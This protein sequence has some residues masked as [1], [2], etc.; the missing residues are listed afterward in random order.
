[1]KDAVLSGQVF[2]AVLLLASLLSANVDA[3]DDPSRRALADTYRSHV[4]PILTRY[5]LGC[6]SEESSEGDLDLERFPSYDAARKDVKP[7]Q[8]MVEMLESGEMPPRKKPQPTADERRRLIAWVRDFLASE[9]IARAGDPGRVGLRRL[10]NAEYDGT[11]RELTTVDLRPAREFP[12]DGAAGEGFTNASEALNMS[13]ALLAKYLDAAKEIA[14]HAILLPDGFRFSRGN[15]RRDW[16]DESV[17]GLREFYARYAGG[18]GRLPIGPYLSALVR[19]REALASGAAGVEAVA[20]SEKLHPGYLSAVFRALSAEDH[21]IPMDRLRSIWMEAPAD[22]GALGS[23]VAAWQASLWKFQPIGSYRYGNIVRQAA[24]EPTWTESG[25]VRVGRKPAPGEDDVVL[26]LVAGDLSGADGTGSVEWHR[27][28]FERSGRPALL[29]RDYEEFGP[30]YEI[31]RA[32]L[33]ADAP[34]YLAAAIEAAADRRLA[35]DAL[36]ARDDLDPAWLRRW[37]AVAAPQSGA[38]DDVGRPTPAVRLELLGDRKPAGPK[39]NGWSAR[40]ADLPTLIANSSDRAEQVPGRISPHQVAVHPTPSECAAVAWT[41]PIGGRVRVDARVTHAH[42]TCGNG[43]GWWLESRRGD[44]A[45]ILAEG[46]LGLGKETTVGPRVLD[47]S[48]G[49]LVVLAVDA[50]EG[51]H[52]C[53]LTEIALSLSESGGPARRWDLAADVA[54]NVGEGNPHPDR[55]GN[56]AVWSFLKGPARS[57]SGESAP[58]VPAGSILGRW[59]EAAADPGRRAEAGGLAGRLRD[60]LAGPRPPE[61]TGPDRKLYDNLA[62]PD[63]PLMGEIPPTL[64]ARSRPRPGRYGPDRASFVG[65]GLVAPTDRVIQ[66]RLPAALFRDHEFAVDGKL[67]TA[68]GDRVVH[69]QVTTGPPAPGSRWDGKSPLVAAPGGLARGRLLAGFEEF[70]R[71]FPPFICYP[72]VIPDDEVVCLK[73]FHRED[74]PLIRLFLDEEQARRIDRLWEEHRFISKFPAVEDEYLPLF[75]GFVT[76]DQPGELLRYFEG[77]REPFRRRADRFREDYEAAAPGQLRALLDFAARA[78]RRPLAE[79]EKGGLLDLY[80]GLRGKGVSHEDAFRGV[81]ARVLVSPSF[82]YHLEKPPPGK[83]PGPVDDW[84]LASRL[85]YFLWSAPPDDALRQDAAAGRLREPAVLARQADRMLKD[86]RSRALAIEFGTQWIHVRG[87]DALKEKDEGLFPTFDAGLRGAIYEESILFFQDLF[88]NDRPA[89]QLLDADYTFLDETLARH[90]GIPGVE[91]PGWRRVDGVKKYGRG[92]LLGL[93]SVL[94]SQSGA[95]RTSP[96]LRGNWVVETL[97][98]EK[99]PRPP[100]NIPQLPEAETGNDG[101]TMRQLVEKHVQ[102]EGCAVCHRRIDPFGFA[103]EKYDPIGRLRE[104]DLGGLPVDARSRP[105]E[106]IEFEGIDGLRAYLLAEKR[107]VIVRLFCRRLLGYALGREVA[108]SDRPLIDAMASGT[109]GRDARASSMVLAIVASPQFRSIR[110]ASFVEDE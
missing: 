78:Y 17:A 4:R 76:Q 10:S 64:R 43:V 99:L 32:A 38:A 81:L 20:R 42:P 90:Y 23:E 15:T 28:R 16:T 36:A 5:C 68:A 108:L 70:R 73:T 53:D 12:A 34:R 6:H 61:A 65:D 46:T 49:D 109:D 59:R 48:P 82:L 72:R 92:G 47:V 88:R 29:L 75:I 44:R 71:L 101:L 8:A 21:S 80:R 31:D 84:E 67:G 39:I 55:L 51:D 69:F 7:W 96:V 57:V 58:A 26:H 66:I 45:T 37:I 105:R 77:Q 11:I 110:G 1:M 95:S 56:K 98:G 60:L 91:G 52:S 14:S 94:A 79:A 9:A 106:G 107:D 27:P 103:L 18:D 74:E 86:E 3:G 13:P 63:G 102:A 24:N 83:E 93:A 30:G 19:H 104:K 100:A 89:T 85:S 62:S 50:R 22:G 54:G 97:L 33:F 40:G 41:S 87:F 35:V 2:V 25:T